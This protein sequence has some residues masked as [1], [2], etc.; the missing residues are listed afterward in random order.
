MRF[1]RTRG[2]WPT[3]SRMWLHFISYPFKPFQFRFFPIALAM[4]GLLSR[5]I[6]FTMH[7]SIHPC[8]LLSPIWLQE[9]LNESRRSAL[10]FCFFCISVARRESGGCTVKRVGGIVAMLPFRGPFRGQ[11]VEV[12]KRADAAVDEIQ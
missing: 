11:E 8:V 2:V 1:R 10:L 4:K 9:L 3:A 7:L 6:Q 12:P 5:L